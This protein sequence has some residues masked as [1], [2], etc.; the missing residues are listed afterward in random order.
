[1][2]KLQTVYVPTSKIDMSSTGYVLVYGRSKTPIIEKQ[3]ILITQERFDEMTKVLQEIT[4]GSY[5]IEDAKLVCNQLLTQ[6]N[7]QL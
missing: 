6:L 4:N 5:S 1:M 7:N 2:N 3:A